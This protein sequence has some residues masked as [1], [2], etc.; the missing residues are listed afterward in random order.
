MSERALIQERLPSAPAEYDVGYMNRLVGI[1]DKAIS[2]LSRR[3]RIYATSINANQLPTSSTGLEV[4]ELWN[5]NGTVKV[6]Q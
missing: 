1:I 4:G 5:D 3:R 6:K 2:L